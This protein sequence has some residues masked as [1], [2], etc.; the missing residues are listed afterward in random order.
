M[1]CVPGMCIDPARAYTRNPGF[2]WS[3]LKLG[4]LGDAKR[5][6]AFSKLLCMLSAILDGVIH[7]TTKL[8]IQEYNQFVVTLLVLLLYRGEDMAVHTQAL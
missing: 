3:S 5:R 2:G 8:N 4:A 6:H 1:F 7:L